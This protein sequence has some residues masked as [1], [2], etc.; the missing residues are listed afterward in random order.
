V[1][2]SVKIGELVSSNNGKYKLQQSADRNRRL[3][4]R[5]RIE[6]KVSYQSL[7]FFEIR[8]NPY[9]PRQDGYSLP[10]HILIS[11]ASRFIF[12]L[13]SLVFYDKNT[14]CI[15]IIRSSAI[16][17]VPTAKEV[18]IRMETLCGRKVSDLTCVFDQANQTV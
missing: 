5:R 9:S 14:C 7:S 10:D 4:I 1:K 3:D 8:P 13:C 12:E 15:S 11:L 16:D 18:F 2:F 6:A 17:I